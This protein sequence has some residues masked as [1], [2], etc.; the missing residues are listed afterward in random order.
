[1]ILGMI[2]GLIQVFVLALLVAC[3]IAT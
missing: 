2:L 3:A 1:M